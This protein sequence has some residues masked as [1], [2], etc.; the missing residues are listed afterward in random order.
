MLILL[1]YN[2][3]GYVYNQEGEPLQAALVILQKDTLKLGGTYTDED[4]FFKLMNVEPGSYRIKINI[5]GYK[6]KT[7]EVSVKDK[8]VDL[9]R[10]V[11]E[12]KAIT[13]KEVE[14][15]AEAPKITYEGEKK[16]I[17]FQDEITSKAGNALDALRNVPGI[18][19]DNNDNV[20][21]RNT[22]KI[23]LYIN[24]KPTVFEPSEILRQI[25]ASSVERIEIIT[26]P[27]AK[28]E[29]RGSVIMNIV[30]KKQQRKGFSSS[31]MGR[32]GTY[33]NYGGNGS[34]G[35]NT[36]AT[37][38]ILSAYYFTFTRFIDN[39]VNV[40][41]ALNYSAEGERFYSMRPYGIR[42][43]LEHNITD[44]DIISFE[45]NLG[46]W[47]FMMGWSL[48]Y[49]NYSSNMDVS[50]GGFNGSLSAGYTKKFLDAHEIS[51]LAFYA[52]RSGDEI[53]ES[54]S[55]DA[56]DNTLGG[57]KRES[58]GP[59]SRGRFKVDYTY[60]ISKDRKFEIGY[61]GD[62]E[63]S[64]EDMKFYD[65]I[66]GD[67]SLD[68]SSK[69]D[70]SEIIHAAYLS[71]GNRLGNFTYNLGIRGEYNERII[72]DENNTYTY[73]IF[74]PFPT[75]HISYNLNVSNQIMLS[76]SRRVWYPRRWMLNPFIRKIDAINYQKGNPELEPEFSH[77]FEMG[78]QRVIKL[79]N[80]GI[81]GFYKRSDKGIDFY[82]K[83][84]RSVGAMV[85]TWRNVGYETSYGVETYTTLKPWKLLSLNLSVNIYKHTVYADSVSSSFTYDFKGSINLG[86]GPIGLQLTG[87]YNSPKA[88]A[89]GKTSESYSLDIGLRLP[90]SR[91][92]FFIFQFENLLRTDTRRIY[93]EDEGFRMISTV[94]PKWPSISAMLMFDYNNFYKMRKR[95]RESEDLREDVPMF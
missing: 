9:G 8:D 82:P 29:A 61:N 92:I 93:I 80:I 28:Y 30:M 65:Y 20:I 75:L 85:Y 32:L 48:L 7:L 43:S 52:T 86:Y 54:F 38:F 53:T 73:K 51:L 12:Q 16:V 79:G 2:I 39:D 40:E 37:R 94:S 66:S 45:G 35:V 17:R 22:S 36:S 81:E 33:Q 31:L 76:Y 83:Y 91:N 89:N 47:K 56:N 27:S 58:S 6:E 19:V 62:I 67:F 74:A 23:T 14:V 64:Y 44:N 49:P 11:M 78:Y 5:I 95:K 10:I 4:G 24:G 77:S 42:A 13:V 34:V 3:T 59:F 41:G 88:S 63:R 60:K 69:Y 57:F 71:Y 68:T 26:N 84:D 21:I 18:T 46:F 15:E 90:L 25:P 70:Y 55:R 50:I 87:R 1:A 72:K